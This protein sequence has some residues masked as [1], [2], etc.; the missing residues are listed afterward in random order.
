MCSIII[1]GYTCN[2]VFT[3]VTFFTFFTFRTIGY[4]KFASF[5]ITSSNSDDVRTIWTFFSGYSRCYAVYTIFTSSTSFTFC[6]IGYGK[7]ASFLITSSNSDDVRT[8]WTFF[9]GYSRRY[10][11][12]TIFTSSTFCTFITLRSFDVAFFAPCVVILN[13]DVTGFCIDVFIAVFTLACFW[14]NFAV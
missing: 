11:V 4:G 2:S 6:T 12:Y 9:S 3:V 8:I 13:E 1:V 7:F 10:A 14:G 5:L